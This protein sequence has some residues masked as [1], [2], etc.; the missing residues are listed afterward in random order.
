MVQPFVA[1]VKPVNNLNEVLVVPNPFVIDEG[2]TLPGEG[3]NIQFVNIPNPCT[4]RIYTIRGDLV[5]TIEVQQG[6]G[7]IAEWDQVTDF[8]QFVESGI[9][10]YHIDS[11]VGTKIGKFAIVR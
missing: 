4:I 10:I 2:Y 9:Y 11:Q 5:K 6:D 1:T 8:G 3:D 7:A